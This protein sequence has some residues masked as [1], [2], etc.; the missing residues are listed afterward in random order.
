MKPIR[1]K[2]EEIAAILD[3]RKSEKRIPVKPQPDEKHSYLLGVLVDSTVKRTV[4]LFG[5]G[6]QEYGG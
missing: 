2:Q 6:S 5:F 4:G 3:G 1:L